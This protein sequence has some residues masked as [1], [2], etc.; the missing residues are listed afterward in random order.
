MKVFS[1]NNKWFQC[2]FLYYV[3]GA[4]MRSDELT[5]CFSLHSPQKNQERLVLTLVTLWTPVGQVMT[6]NW[7]LRSPTT[8]TMAT[9]QWAVIPSPVSWGMMGSRCGTRLCRRVKVGERHIKNC[10]LKDT[11]CI[12]MMEHSCE[13]KPAYVNRLKNNMLAHTLNGHL[14]EHICTM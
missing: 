12:V 1:I 14:T 10:I 13:A 9:Q 8:A 3:S 4:H 7:D 11:I 6:T 5:R 2:L